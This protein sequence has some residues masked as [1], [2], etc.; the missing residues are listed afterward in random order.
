MNKPLK[1]NYSCP[2]CG[3][4]RNCESTNASRLLDWMVTLL[5]VCVCG[6]GFTEDQED[7]VSSVAQECVT[8]DS[9]ILQLK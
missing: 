7:G 9:G 6:G 2:G 1:A 5:G 4:E 3:R 8:L